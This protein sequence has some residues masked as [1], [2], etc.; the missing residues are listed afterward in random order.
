MA[1]YTINYIT[2]LTYDDLKDMDKNKLLQLSRQASSY[3]NTRRNGVI[4]AINKNNLPTPHVLSEESLEKYSAIITGK[5][6]NKLGHNE[7]IHNILLSKQFLLTKTSTLGGWKE[8]LNKGVKIIQDITDIKINKKDYSYFYEVVN[9][10]NEVINDNILNERYGVYRYVAEAIND[11]EY[12]HY[13]A[14]E[15]ATYLINKIENDLIHGDSE[16][17]D[18]NE[19]DRKYQ[20]GSKKNF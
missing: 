17:D 12:S 14:K 19:F 11:I 8:V 2:N 6:N 4:S 20:L 1:K 3:V 7:L 18:D 10:V 9:R 15:L 5:N 13:D 16:Q